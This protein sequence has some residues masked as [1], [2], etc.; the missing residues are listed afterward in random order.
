MEIQAGCRSRIFTV[1]RY[2]K[3]IELKRRLMKQPSEKYRL[4]WRSDVTRLVKELWSQ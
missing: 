4:A 2:S 3:A 1:D